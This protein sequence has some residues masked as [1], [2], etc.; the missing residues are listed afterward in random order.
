MEQSWLTDL[1]IAEEQYY[2]DYVL[3]QSNYS[4]EGKSGDWSSF[5]LESWQSLL[6]LYSSA[7]QHSYDSQIISFQKSSST[8]R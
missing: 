3:S 1:L 8:A 2:F 6:V 4:Q 7:G 5:C